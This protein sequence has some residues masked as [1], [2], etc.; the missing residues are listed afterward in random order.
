MHANLQ[1]LWFSV[2]PAFC[3][4]NVKKLRNSKVCFVFL[5]LNSVKAKAQEPEVSVA[6]D[7]FTQFKHLLL[8]ITDRK[9]YLSEGTKQVILFNLFL[10]FPA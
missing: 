3:I 4:E 1:L 7:A 8:P 9:P 10:L 6:T 2:I 5:Y